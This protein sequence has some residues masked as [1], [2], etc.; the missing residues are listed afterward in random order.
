M[1]KTSNVI[2]NMTRIT[3]VYEQ[4]AAYFKILIK[5]QPQV[6]FS[7]NV[8]FKLPTPNHR[9]MV[10]ISNAMGDSFGNWGI[11]FIILLLSRI[12]PQK[13]VCCCEITS[14]NTKHEKIIAL[15][16][17]AQISIVYHFS[18]P[19]SSACCGTKIASKWDF[20]GCFHQSVYC[21]I[22]FFSTYNIC[23]CFCH[24]IQC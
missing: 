1:S 5:S 9:E 17:S 18:C 11:H 16:V 15:Y 4:G 6:F 19:K 8:S 12:V 10:N 24:K 23:H 2:L 20:S 7:P 21:E 3:K 13:N 14:K 22:Y